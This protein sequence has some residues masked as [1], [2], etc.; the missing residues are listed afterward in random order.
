MR[1]AAVSHRTLSC[2][3]LPWPA[4]DLAALIK[5]LGFQVEADYVERALELFGGHQ[6]ADISGGLPAVVEFGE[7]FT[8]LYDVLTEGAGGGGGGGGGDGDDGLPAGW[9]TQTSRTTGELYYVHTVTG[10]SQFERPAAA[11]AGSGGSHRER[12]LP[13]HWVET[14]SRSTGEV[15]YA[16]ELTGESTFDRPGGGG[17][18]SGGGAGADGAGAAAAGYEVPGGDDGAGAEPEGGGL[19]GGLPCPAGWATKQSRSTGETYYV[20][21][22]TGESQF[23]PPDGPAVPS[24]WS[25]QRSRSTREVYYVNDATGESQFEPPP[26]ADDAAAADSASDSAPPGSTGGGGGGGP[27]GLTLPDG[28]ER[29]ESRSHGGQPYYLNIWTGETQ[30]EFPALPALPSGW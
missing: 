28:W 19:F 9:T 11:T 14:V 22:V 27:A 7:K 12:P 25:L 15:Y 26:L 18:G 10:A 30:F 3:V 20:N 1:S 16:N 5:R 21:T 23:E 24:G 29:H 17:G 8:Q 13:P 4:D 2:P 6:P